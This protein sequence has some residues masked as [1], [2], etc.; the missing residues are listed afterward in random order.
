M[1]TLSKESL[2]KRTSKKDFNKL[3]RIF[4][5]L[6]LLEITPVRYKN[7]NKKEAVTKFHFCNGFLILVK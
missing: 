7:Q 6:S 2:L 5:N 4:I 1:L 3:F